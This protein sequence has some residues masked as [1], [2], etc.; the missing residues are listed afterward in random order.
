MAK[1]KKKSK[2]AT[3]KKRKTSKPEPAMRITRGRG[4]LIKELAELLVAIAPGSSRGTTSFSVKWV[5][6]EFGDKKLWKDKSNKLKSTTHF[7][8]GLFRT[9]PNKPKK[10]VLEIV[11]GGLKW[12]AKKGEEVSRD[13]L[14]LISDKLNELGVNAKKELRQIEIPEP[15]RIATPPDDL[16]SITKQVSLHPALHEDCVAMFEAGHLNE[17][18]RKAMERFEKKI[19][20]ATGLHDVGKSLMGKAFNAD[21]PLIPINTGVAANDTS[22]REGFMHLTMGAMM[23]MRNLYSH[24]DVATMTPMDA[25]ERLC[26]VSLLFKRVDAALGTGTT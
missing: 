3:R 12:K 5:A 13:H 26:F 8:E 21:N 6:H 1:K 4:Q 10:I 22:E 17:A 24:G 11:K 18:V 19:Q 2:K 14:M 9:Y 25:F 15:S 20:D 16:T 7:L 23:S